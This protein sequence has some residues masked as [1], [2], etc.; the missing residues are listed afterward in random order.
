MITIS[1]EQAMDAGLPDPLTDPY[2]IRM[3][4]EDRTLCSGCGEAHEFSNMWLSE[5]QLKDVMEHFKS[6]TH[7]EFITPWIFE[8]VLMPYTCVEVSTIQ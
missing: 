2:V 7:F 5:E 8:D 3:P 6:D 4:N 1:R